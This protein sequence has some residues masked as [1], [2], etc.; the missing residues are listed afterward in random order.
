MD[1]DRGLKLSDC[2]KTE[3]AKLGARQTTSCLLAKK[4][5][6]ITIFCCSGQPYK[7]KPRERG[8][9]CE[10]LQLGGICLSKHAEKKNHKI[11][12]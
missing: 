10:N 7:P 9:H 4:R 11:Q 6:I 2:C 3:S 12:I 8:R 5:N 1:L